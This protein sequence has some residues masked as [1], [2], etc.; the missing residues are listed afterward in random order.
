MA[1]PPRIEAFFP[2]AGKVHFLSVHPVVPW[3]AIALEKGAIIVVDWQSR[4]VIYQVRRGLLW[5][6]ML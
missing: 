5:G 4:H 2:T 1:Q 3:V 6:R